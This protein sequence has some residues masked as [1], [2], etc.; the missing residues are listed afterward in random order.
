MILIGQY[1]SPFVRRVAIAL[2]LYGLEFDHRPWSV[3]AD[4]E[5]I[6]TFN[7]LRRVP[8]LVLEGLPL[9]E[10]SAILDSIDDLVDPGRALLP[11]SGLQRREGLRICSLAMGLADKAV[12]LLYEHLLRSEE[13]RSAIWVNR[14]QAQ[15]R[16]ALSVLEADRRERATPFW[17]GDRIGHPDIA[18]ACAL[19]FLSE[20]HPALLQAAQWP[21]LTA[22]ATRCEALP[23][24]KEISQ[25]LE[26]KVPSSS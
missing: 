18:V 14:C 10:S 5:R 15:I 6:A 13:R 26:V 12:T 16:D 7:P 22:H 25:P 3:W 2:R 17:Q 23:V 8:V 9:V 4:A 24:F 21:S 11:R 20:S 1:D 19:R